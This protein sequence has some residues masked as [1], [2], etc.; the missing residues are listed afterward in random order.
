MSIAEIDFSPVRRP[1][2][3]AR[4]L[5]NACYVDPAY[6]ALERDRLFA[7]SWACVGVAAELPNAGDYRPVNL[8]GLPLLLLRD[9]AH[10]IRVFHNVC[11]HR[12][13]ALVDRPGSG[14][15]IRCPYHS[16]SYDLTGR[17]VRTP[18]IGG[19]GVHEMPL[20]DR[21]ELGLREIRT[22]QWLDFVFVNLSGDAE[23][24]DEWLAPLV[25]MWS[26]Y[27]L[28]ELR[29][30]GT[31]DFTIKANWKLATENT[32]EFYHLPW[33]H[34]ALTG[35]SPTHAHYHCN[36]GDRFVGTATRDY[37]PSATSGRQ[38]PKFPGLT[39][40]QE[41]VG[42]YPVVFPNLWV[43]VQVDHFFAIVIYPKAPDV[44]EQ[45]LH[46]YFVGN[47]A[48]GSEYDDLRREIVERWRSINLEDISI[49]ERMQ[50]GRQSP[51]FDG[52]RMSPVQD[53]AI[54]HFMRMVAARMAQ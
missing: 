30:G 2:A 52:G 12:G 11:S 27:D 45:R 5:P 48:M 44:T 24:L 21:A 14:P 54:H 33:V 19:P 31:A 28:T 3:Q 1:T 40:E 13:V 36:A 38:L 8:L 22:G 26:H 51:A 29:H 10:A 42:E 53:F 4:G 18:D 39:A 34:Q 49:T 41:L 9:R 50:G 32:M 17:L 46:L 7:R 16:W 15:V 6:F 23:P 47:K 43:G 20:I 25:R 37:R 35:Y